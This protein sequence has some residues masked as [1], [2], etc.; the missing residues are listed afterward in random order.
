MKD[1]DRM[2]KV[3][4]DQLCHWERREQGCDKRMLSDVSRGP[5]VDFWAHCLLA[6]LPILCAWDWSWSKA[7]DESM[8]HRHKHGKENN[9]MLESE[10]LRASAVIL[11]QKADKISSK[12]NMFTRVRWATFA[13]QWKDSVTLLVQLVGH[14][15][16]KNQRVF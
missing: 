14:L 16:K 8:N 7:P 13:T 1:G 5:E 9:F 12:R 3:G 11:K 2:Q 10:Y 6:A 15:K 4:R